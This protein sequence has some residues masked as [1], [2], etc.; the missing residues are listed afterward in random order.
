M[1]LAKESDL[2]GHCFRHSRGNMFGIM[3]IGRAYRGVWRF[4]EQLRCQQ[5]AAELR[6][7][8]APTADHLDEAKRLI[9]LLPPISHEAEA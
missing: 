8:E 7:A 1:R 3:V 9:V 2:G 4:F 6:K 5:A